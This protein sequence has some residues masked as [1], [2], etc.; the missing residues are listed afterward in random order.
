MPRQM[1]WPLFKNER[2]PMKKRTKDIIAV[3]WRVGLAIGEALWYES[4]PKGR[5][6]KPRDP[7]K[8]TPG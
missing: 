6:R 4:T 8:R 5:K 2:R 1:G 3:I 7:S